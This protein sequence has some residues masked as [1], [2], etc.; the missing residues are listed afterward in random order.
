MAFVLRAGLGDDPHAPVAHASG[1]GSIPAT[2]AGTGMASIVLRVDRGQGRRP[3][4]RAAPSSGTP[5]PPP[6]RDPVAVDFT[7]G[8]G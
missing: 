5:A 8:P 4:T 7:D 1:A 2:F 6:G 3:R